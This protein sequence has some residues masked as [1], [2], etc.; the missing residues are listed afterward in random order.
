MEQEFTRN[1]TRNNSDITF[2]SKLACGP[3]IRRLHA[4]LSAH[5]FF[6]ET[7]L[8]LLNHNKLLLI[9]QISAYAPN[10][11]FSFTSPVLRLLYLI[12]QRKHSGLTHQC[13]A[14]Q[15]KPDGKI[16][17]LVAQHLLQQ[18]HFDN[19]LQRMSKKINKKLQDS[20][21]TNIRRVKKNIK[22]SPLYSRSNQNS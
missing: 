9:N 14:W 17:L 7:N 19:G 13:G 16:F 22:K 2:N 18:A 10:L 11:S 15:T 1:M 4:H 3:F 21:P 8:I 6:S 12:K 5:L 20:T